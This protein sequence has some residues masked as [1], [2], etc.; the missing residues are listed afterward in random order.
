MAIV[1][2]A[3]LAPMIAP[4]AARSQD[5]RDLPPF[6]V[7]SI[8]PAARSTTLWRT[9]VFPDG[10][11]EGR[12]Q[13]RGL[14]A[15]AWRLEPYQH[16]IGP[17]SAL[18]QWFVIQAKVAAGVV[19]HAEDYPLLVQRLL[20]ERFG[21][22]VRFED[23]MQTVFVLRRVRPDHLGPGL[24][25]STADCSQPISPQPEPHLAGPPPPRCRQVE[26]VNG[27]FTG[28]FDTLADFAGALSLYAQRRFVDGTRLEGQYEIEMT[29]DPATLPMMQALPS[30][31]DLPAF[32]DALRDDLGLRSESER[33]PI[34]RL[35]V[36]RID[37]LVP[38]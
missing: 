32:S 21:L 19:V 27:R 6:E 30:N 18:D 11:F 25:P 31:L 16:I 1:A 15:Y 17:G 20:M 5:V 4:R 35:V 28:I 23:E 3:W 24:R 7:A 8:R 34:P 22:R 2:V 38:N 33:R 14:I 37:P 36:E 26:L 12:D 13:L 29:F 9:R 10:R